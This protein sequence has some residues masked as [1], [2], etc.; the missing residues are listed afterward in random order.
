MSESLIKETLNCSLK[1]LMSS[2]RHRT[3]NLENKMGVVKIAPH[4]CRGG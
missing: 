1:N 3:V 2:R 4:R